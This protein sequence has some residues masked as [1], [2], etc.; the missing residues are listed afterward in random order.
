MLDNLIPREAEVQTRD[1]R[2]YLMRILPYRTIDNVIEGAVLT[3]VDIARQKR[4]EE[5]VRALSTD[6]ER[7]VSER[8]AELQ[9]SNQN[10][11]REIRQ[12]Q[13]AEDR[14]ATDIAALTRLHDL[15]ALLPQEGALQNLL[16]ASLDAAIELT[17]GDMGMLQLYDQPS[18]TLRLAAHRGFDQPFLSHFGTIGAASSASCAEAM[19]RGERVVVEDITNCPLFADSPTLPVLQAARVR[20]VQSTPVLARDGRLLAM[21]ST[22]WTQPHRPDEGTLRLLDLLSRQLADLIAQ[23]ERKE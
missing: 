18:Q 11:E 3:F 8:V 4:V 19:R 9:Q 12:R 22:H 21:F 13:A 17:R 7:R 20:A 23:R 2:W 16:Q 10:L 14:R 1:G 15:G 6:L 5:E